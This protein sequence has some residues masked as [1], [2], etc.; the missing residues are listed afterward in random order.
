MRDA[1]FEQSVGRQIAL[2]Q[3]RTPSE[4]LT[5]L[6]ELLDAVRAM[7]PAGEEARERRMRALS[8][9]RLERE[10]WRA[11]CRRLLTAQR[12]DPRAGI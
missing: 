5:A 10:Q 1:D 4:R 8:A 3:A 2:N 12:T 11:Q 7:A 9:R 6:C